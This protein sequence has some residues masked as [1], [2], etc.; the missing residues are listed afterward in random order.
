MAFLSALGGL[1]LGFVLCLFVA[2]FGVIGSHKSGATGAI[3]AV[4]LPI[5][6]IA[7][8][9]AATRRRNLPF[10]I[11]FLIGGCLVVLLAGACGFIGSMR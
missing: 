10:A 7:G 3:S 6:A 8:I 4:I 2:M 1:V 11:G 9:F 5:L